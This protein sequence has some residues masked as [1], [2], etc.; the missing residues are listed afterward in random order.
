[1]Q[2]VWVRRCSYTQL[3]T[4][5]SRRKRRQSGIQEHRLSFP[6]VIKGTY[7]VLSNYCL[8]WGRGLQEQNPPPS[9]PNSSTEE[10][11]SRKLNQI[12][13]LHRRSSKLSNALCLKLPPTH[14]DSCFSTKKVSL[15]LAAWRFRGSERPVF[16]ED[17]D[18]C[19]QTWTELQRLRL[20]S[21]HGGLD[22]FSWQQV[23]VPASLH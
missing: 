15:S 8:K 12:A 5:C 17:V 7:F 14:Q 6:A 3:G 9:S 2:K 1:M 18:E 19:L 13:V 22:E 20:C 11:S 21:P 16:W 4:F 10:W 23:V